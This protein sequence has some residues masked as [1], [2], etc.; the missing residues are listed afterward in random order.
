MLLFE[1][2]AVEGI[3]FL[4]EQHKQD[5][6]YC[7]AIGQERLH[8]ADGRF[9][10]QRFWK[11]IYPGRDIWKGN[12]CKAMFHCKSKAVPVTLS[13]KILF[14]LLSAMPDWANC[15]DYIRC[16]KL[17]CRCDFGFTGTASLKG[18]TGFK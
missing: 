16:R 11:A 18:T 1:Y 12:G 5:L 13:Q 10:C 4:I 2:M 7:F 9:S 14:L 17:K 8:H 3:V 6:D 15:V